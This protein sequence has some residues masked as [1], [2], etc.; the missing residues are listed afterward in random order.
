[1]L[2]TITIAGALANPNQ[3]LHLKI[4]M[5]GADH[6]VMVQNAEWRILVAINDLMKQ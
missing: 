3:I 4:E 6:L 5:T 2:E 1:M